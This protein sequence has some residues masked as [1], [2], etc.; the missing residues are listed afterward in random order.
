MSPAALLAALACT[1]VVMGSL[2]VVGIAGRRILLP[3]WR[4]SA[5]VTGGM[6][7]VLLSTVALGQVLGAVGMLN[8]WAAVVSAFAAAA[9]AL[10]AMRRWAPSGETM[11]AAAPDPGP[12]ASA[13]STALATFAI[14]VVL[15]FWLVRTVVA[16]R[17]GMTDPDSVGYHLP[18]T[19]VF[20]STGVADPNRLPHAY[21]P[22][23][24]YPGND[25]LISAVALAVS[26]SV[27][28]STVKNLLLAIGSL[29][30]A[31]AIG[32]KAR[33]S[34]PAMVSVAVVL[35]LPIA[36]FTVPGHAKN[37]ALVV[38]AVLVGLACLLLAGEKAAP[39]VL[40]AGCGGVVTGTK[41]SSV[42]AGGALVLWALAAVYRR[43]RT[44]RWRT[45]ALAVLA[46]LAT[47][48]PWYVRNL[49]TF[50]N[51][52]PLARLSIGPLSLPSI[53][54]VE[55]ERTK[56]IASFLLRRQYY[57]ATFFEG[58]V[59]AVGPVGLLVVLAGAVGLLVGLRAG[60]WRR[61]TAAFGLLLT[62]A[63]LMTPATAYTDLEGRPI[64]YGVLI[65]VHYALPA[66]AVCL[67]A[68]AL[69]L[70]TRLTSWALPVLAVG[71]TL[72]GLP[73]G[74]EF[75]FWFTEVGG[76]GFGVLV[77]AAAAGAVA[78]GLK[79]SGQAGWWRATA[80]AAIL[81]PLC[82][83]SIVA[84]QPDQRTEDPVARYLAAAPRARI[85]ANVGYLGTLYGPGGRHDVTILAR[86]VDRVPLPFTTCRSFMAEVAARQSDLVAV[87]IAG[88][89]YDWAVADPA[90][91]LEAAGPRS[92][93]YSVTG[94]PGSL[95]PPTP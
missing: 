49:L 47:G 2:T 33:A 75:A 31:H 90:L 48:V 73:V 22:I 44:R 60:G 14:L 7:I 85:A 29:V 18:L 84:S 77:L 37:D 28:F 19:H 89:A 64:A 50:G 52:V 63:Y 30:A 65:N 91:R 88:E 3:S 58:L 42:V 4:G 62:I 23:Y 45:M 57:S 16:L 12:R 72:A 15:G 78:A 53:P 61:G 81:T 87:N 38:F 67:L 36:A 10:V 93:L 92:Q 83:A 66:A 95:C 17:R 56:S 71:V 9:A 55:L 11:G 59:G 79:R 25:E 46:S 80:V 40:A 13:T 1:A 70:P 20:A 43:G 26:Q 35:G 34:V 41:L 32:A 68:L 8:R 27:V 86:V 39:L 76:A 21:L 24:T 5:A 54:S 94:V 51:P 82:L 6:A 69:S 74:R